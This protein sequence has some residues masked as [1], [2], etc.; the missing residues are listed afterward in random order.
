MENAQTP[1]TETKKRITAATPS[2]DLKLK[3]LSNTISASWNR[4]PGITLLWNQAGDFEITAKQF[5]SVLGQRLS[6]AG[7][8]SVMTNELKSLVRKADLHIDFVKDYLKEKYGKEDCNS[9][10]PQF[11]IVKHKS[12]FKF[13]RDHNK[14]SEAIERTVEAIETNGFQDKSSGLVFWQDLSQQYN[15]ALAATVSTDG[16]VSGLVKTK[17]KHREQIKK[18]LNALI[19]AIKA[20]YPDTWTSVLREWGFQKEKY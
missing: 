20:N 8:R 18:T 15:A 11:G 5:S 19:H 17:N 14:M 12:S 16:N 7:G 9:Y 4:N 6:T 13:P 1:V 3:D 2:S 10:Y